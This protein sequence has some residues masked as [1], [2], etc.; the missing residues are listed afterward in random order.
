MT[1]QQQKTWQQLWQLAR[2]IA[3][4]QADNTLVLCRSPDPMVPELDHSHI[5]V[6]VMTLLETA[7][8]EFCIKLLNQKTKVHKY[9]S[10]LV[11]AMAVLGRGEQGWRDPDSYPPTI[12]CVLKVAWFLVVQKASWLDPQH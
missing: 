7:C 10:L 4:D 12:S 11:C 1:M 5:K 9:E 2:Q 8:L 3:A 6:F